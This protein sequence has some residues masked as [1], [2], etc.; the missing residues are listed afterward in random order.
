M[1]EFVGADQAFQQVF[2]HLRCARD[3]EAMADARPDCAPG[4][5]KSARKQRA[6]AM[7]LVLEGLDE[8]I[9]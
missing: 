2:V 1:F 4:L 7:G 3:S 8:P 6:L 9:G 5:F